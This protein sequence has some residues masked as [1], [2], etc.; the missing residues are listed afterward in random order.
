MR[1]K[2]QLFHGDCLEEMKNI[3]DGIIDLILCDL[4]YGTTDRH[5]LDSEKK[6]NRVFSW[7]SVI[8]LDLL[9]EQYKRIL[10]PKGTV[11]LTADQPFTSQLVVSNLEWFKYE[12]I[13]VKDKK[14]GFLLANNRP[15]KQTEDI[16]IFSPVGAS[17]ASAKA[18]NSMTYN[19]QGLIPKTVKKKNISH[20][21]SLNIAD[22]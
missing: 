13:W 7:D 2:F 1:K 16:L 18:N 12:W 21:C 14:V 19:P 6:E 8:P 20:F 11:V 9:W 5:G 22:D 15:M 17:P 10:K 4:P 3:E